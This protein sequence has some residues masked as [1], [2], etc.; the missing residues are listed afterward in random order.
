M[1]LFLGRAG[2]SPVT[3]GGA[4]TVVFWQRSH[5]TERIAA[6]GVVGAGSPESV[7]PRHQPLLPALSKFLQASFFLGFRAPR[8]AALPHARASLLGRLCVWGASSPFA[9]AAARAHTCSARAARGARL[10]PLGRPRPVDPQP[11]SPHAAAACG[12]AP[13]PLIP[14]AASTGE[15]A[16][17]EALCARVHAGGAAG[18]RIRAPSQHVGLS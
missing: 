2:A 18:R 12:A 10:R 8:W 14:R 11:L 16:P 5:R 6:T 7:S 17:R 1:L 3:V 13:R 9:P 4:P 15:L